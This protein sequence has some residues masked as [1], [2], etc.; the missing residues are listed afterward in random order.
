MYEYADVQTDTSEYHTQR[1]M[2]HL[3]ICTSANLQIFNDYPQSGIKGF[4]ILNP[5]SRGEQ[6]TK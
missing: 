5:L 3:H 1:D 4:N 6:K 2:L